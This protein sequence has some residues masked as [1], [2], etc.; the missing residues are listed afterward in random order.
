MKSRKK[1]HFYKVV[2]VGGGFGG[3]SAALRLAKD[4]RC[5]VTLVSDGDSLLYYPLL[6]ATAT[7]ATRKIS[8]IPLARIF[9]GK[10]VQV[11]NDVVVGI[12][13]SRKIIVGHSRQYQYDAVIFALGVVT[14]YFGIDG[15]E[16]NS[17]SIKSEDGVM[18]FRKHLHDELLA[19]KHY[20]KHYVVIG[21]GP[22]GVELAASLK[23]Y[24]LRVGARHGVKQHNVN[25][26]LIEAAPRL[27]PRMSE[28]SSERAAK[29]LRAL[30]VH[31]LLGTA[32]KKLDNETLIAGTR[33]ITTE[34]SVWTSGV[35]NNPFFATHDDIFHLNE[36]GF[37]VVNEYLEAAKGIFVVG[38]NAATKYAGLAQTAISG[39]RYVADV[40]AKRLS[41]VRPG[42]Y[43]PSKPF[44]VVPVG[45][46]WAML[47]RG[48]L[49]L[50]GVPAA[51]L[52]KLAD[53]VGYH[54]LLPFRD[55]L[56]LWLSERQT[57]E[58]GCE[59]CQKN[60]ESSRVA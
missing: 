58:F 36:R 19:T 29:R 4:A 48:W 24:L 56:K 35:C 5:S 51:L 26:T 40:I 18:A 30:G 16:Q 11:V 17:W 50:S 22:T 60:N 33:K 44:S 37:V 7:G 25:I 57:E 2:V 43:F 20:D 23:D 21:G 53:F 10:R 59:L 39:G 52:R 14:N 54:D 38:D 9:S 47:E 27:L 8:S 13:A 49:H 45:H 28:R 12:D 46:S 42:L 55:A 34:T 6:Y 41:G 1:D 3:V 32:V 15:L 31:V